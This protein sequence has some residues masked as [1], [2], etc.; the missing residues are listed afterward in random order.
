MKQQFNLDRRSM[1]TLGA[2]AGVVLTA[3]AAVAAE[4]GQPTGIGDMRVLDPV[5]T[6]LV[7]NL[8]VTCSSPERMAPDERMRVRP[9]AAAARSGRSSV[10]ALKGRTFAAK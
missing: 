5:K 10:D 9:M 8:V 2:A 1:L 4:S 7:M 6:E 3:D